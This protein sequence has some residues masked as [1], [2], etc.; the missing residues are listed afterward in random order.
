MLS[1]MPLNAE[2]TRTSVVGSNERFATLRRSEPLL[3]E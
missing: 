1:P 3:E 2:R